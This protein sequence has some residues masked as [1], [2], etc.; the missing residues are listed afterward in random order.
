MTSKQKDSRSSAN[1]V[2]LKFGAGGPT[3][4]AK[5]PGVRSRSG[6]CKPKSLTP[7]QI[8]GTRLQFPPGGPDIEELRSVT[9]E[10]LVPRLVE[11]FLRVHGVELKHTR[12]HTN[13]LRSSQLGDSGA[14]A[15]EI[16]SQAKQKNQY[17]VL[18]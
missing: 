3:G 7:S 18:K 11:K 10:W 2:G 14:V 12:Q 15:K 1:E 9:R 16:R 8:G 17:R 6:R 5:G 13:R 4:M